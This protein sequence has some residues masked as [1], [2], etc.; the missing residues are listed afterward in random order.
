M[1]AS[2]DEAGTRRFKE[3][4][5][6]SSDDDGHGGEETAL[7]IVSSWAKGRYRGIGS[8]RKRASATAQLL[9]E[10]A[11]EAPP[12]KRQEMLRRLRAL[13]EPDKI[14]KGLGTLLD[15]LI[16]AMGGG[17]PEQISEVRHMSDT[18]ATSR[19]SRAGHLSLYIHVPNRMPMS[20]RYPLHGI[21]TRVMLVQW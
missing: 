4:R 8:M 19:S 16:Q 10:K 11:A 1:V 7:G 5:L 14:L 9:V 18:W 17:A 20:H 6:V 15:A 13:S 12:R 3:L 2:S 21:D